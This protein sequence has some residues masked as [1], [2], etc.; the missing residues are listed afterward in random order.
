MKIKNIIWTFIAKF[1]YPK[2]WFIETLTHN[3]Y[4]F[5]Y[6]SQNKFLICL[7]VYENN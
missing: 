1:I 4:K 6:I 3:K 7:T 5:Y 2:K